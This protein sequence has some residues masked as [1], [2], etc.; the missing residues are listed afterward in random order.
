MS[1]AVKFHPGARDDLHEAIDWYNDERA[2]LGSAFS[3]AVERTVQMAVDA[4]LLDSKV[5]KELRLILVPA[6]P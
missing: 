1:L 3:D 6:F 2:G 4:P 5:G